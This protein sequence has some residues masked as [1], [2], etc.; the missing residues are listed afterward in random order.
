LPKPVVDLNDI[1]L[2]GFEPAFDTGYD[3]LDPCKELGIIT[4]IGFRVG[5]HL[6]WSNE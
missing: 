3:P 1:A 6:G 5:S 4:G 2:I